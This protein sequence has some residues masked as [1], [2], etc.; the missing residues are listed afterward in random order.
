MKQ[1]AIVGC[2]HIGRSSLTH[3]MRSTNEIT[4][5]EQPQETYKITSFNEFSP[6]PSEIKCGKQ[7]RR[8]RRKKNRKRY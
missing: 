8:E 2:R 1:I 4:V 5:L 3:E 6:L 7:L